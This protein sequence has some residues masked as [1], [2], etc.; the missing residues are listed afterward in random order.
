MKTNLKQICYKNS[1]LLP[2]ND[3]DNFFIKNPTMETSLWCRPWFENFEGYADHYAEA[4]EQ[5]YKSITNNTQKKDSLVYPIIFL[6]RH[7]LELRL[8]SILSTLYIL[9]KQNSS[10]VEKSP[11]RGH[12][13]VCL[14]NAIDKLYNGEKKHI[15]ELAEQRIAELNRYD[16][17]SDTFRYHIHK[18]NSSTT[19]KEF[20]DIGAFMSTY[21]KLNTFLEGIEA[22]LQEALDASLN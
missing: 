1:E 11:L 14:W 4:T 18:D 22:E 19:H 7:S 8:K 12:G 9:H 5:L 15:Y 2:L 17:N 21:K 6:S 13:L 20:V 3:S 16:A 10:D